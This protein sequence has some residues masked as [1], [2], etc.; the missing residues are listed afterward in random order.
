FRSNLLRTGMSARRRWFMKVLHVIPSLSL[1]HGG[2]SVALPLI[3]R[4]LVNQTIQVDVATTDDDGP[5]CR[6]NVPLG[7]RIER[8]GYGLFH[9]RKQTEF[10]KCSWPFARWIRR[11]ATDYDL[12]HIHAL[13]SFTSVVAARAALRC[14]LPY[15]IRPLGVLNRWGME[16]RRRV[17]KS[18]SMRL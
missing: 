17:L 8:D 6:M 3:A 1:K 11:H 15:L 9:F 4:S 16:N 12:L 2:P 7:Q 14:G 13:F 5:G 18:L 10:Y